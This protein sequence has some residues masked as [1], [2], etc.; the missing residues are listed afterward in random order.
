MNLGSYRKKITKF[1]VNLTKN[2]EI[3]HLKSDNVRGAGTKIE[4]LLHRFLMM[5]FNIFDYDT[6][7]F[8]IK[9]KL[10]AINQ[11][12]SPF[13]YLQHLLIKT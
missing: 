8:D 10:I 7:V 3:S 2:T 13:S 12:S 1:F 11:N 6:L 9:R 4:S 5:L